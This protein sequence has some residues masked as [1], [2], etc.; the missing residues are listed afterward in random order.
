[1]TPTEITKYLDMA[2]KRKWWIIL[3]FLLVCLAGLT[4]L[5]IT[6]KIYE[7]QTLIV[8]QSQKVPEDFVRSIVSSDVEDRVRTITQEVTSRTNLE[9]IIQE[10]SLQGEFYKGLDVDR[11]VMALRESIKVTVSGT[12]R[13]GAPEAFT[14]SFSG[15]DPKKVADVTNSL[16]SNF[17]T[18]NLKIRESQAIGTSAF[19]ADELESMEKRLKEKEAQLKDYR[20]KNMGG[21][22]EQLDTNLRIIERLQTQLDQINNNLRDAEGRRIILQAQISDLQRGGPVAT[23]P[24]APGTQGGPRDL[25]SLKN[26]LASL[27]SRYTQNHPDV[28]RLKS[29]IARMEAERPSLTADSTETDSALSPAE[30]SLRR[31]LQDVLQ[32]IKSLKEEIDKVQAQ[33]KFYQTKVEETPKREQELLTLNRDYDNEKTL[34]DSMLARKLEAEIAVSM[35]KKQK[36]EQF[37][38]VDPAKTPTI[39]IKPDVRKIILMIL[40]IGL[41]LGGG[42]AFLMETLDTSYKTPEEVKNEVQLPIL[43]SIP[44]IRTENELKSIKRKEILAYAATG[45]GFFLSAASIVLATKGIDKTMEFFKNLFQGSPS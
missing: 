43:V 44:L 27:E 16:A 3:P 20:E 36:G 11:T 31:Q 15:K 12:S 2:Q 22:P 14:I 24:S 10:Y 42:L 1:M 19:L 26:E 40:A 18:E 39:P 25:L 21:L 33:I 29:M 41:G 8:V 32:E 45:V 35:E 7:A 23:T 28:I 17:I 34:Y 13:A 37:R 38:V 6:P 5:M 30:Q 9:K 4:Y